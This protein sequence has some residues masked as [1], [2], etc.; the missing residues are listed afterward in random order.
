VAVDAGRVFVA[1]ANG[2]GIQVI[3]LEH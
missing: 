3:S 2:E 1:S